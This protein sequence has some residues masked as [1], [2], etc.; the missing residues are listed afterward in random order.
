ME[1]VVAADSRILP[2]RWVCGLR[3]VLSSGFVFSQYYEHI[4]GHVLSV[5]GT[6]WSFTVTAVKW[7]SCRQ[8]RREWGVLHIK[9]VRGLPDYQ[10]R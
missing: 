9:Y 5:C 10:L 3:A 7:L 4:L 8:Q 6:S 1:A 2:A